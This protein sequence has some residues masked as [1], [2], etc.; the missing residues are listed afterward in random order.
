MHGRFSLPAG[1]LEPNETVRA[2]AVREARDEVGIDLDPAAL[3]HARLA[4]SRT[5]GNDRTGHFLVATHWSGEPRIREPDKHGELCRAPMSELP[6]RVIPYVR[7]ALGVIA[8]GQ[9]DSEYGWTD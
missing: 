3:R 7:L 8:Q 9:T 4:H 2:T 6:D 1:T 5:A